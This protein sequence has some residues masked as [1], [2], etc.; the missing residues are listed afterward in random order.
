MMNGMWAGSK[1]VEG[2]PQVKAMFQASRTGRRVE[3][4]TEVLSGQGDVAI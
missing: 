2:K 4:L 3:P 1:D